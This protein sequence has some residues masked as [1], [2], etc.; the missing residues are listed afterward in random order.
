MTGGL[1]TA[2]PDLRAVGTEVDGTVAELGLAV[3]PGD[4]LD[5]ADPPAGFLEP[6][7]LGV[8]SHEDEPLGLEAQRPGVGIEDAVDQD[9][10]ALREQ[11]VHVTGGVL[12]GLTQVVQQL[13]AGAAVE[14]DV[15]EPAVGGGQR[16]AA[17]LRV[18]PGHLSRDGV[19]EREV[20]VP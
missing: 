13:C 15:E 12:V 17:R 20:D 2:E 6:E 7:V 3:E 9:E 16:E 8:A 5:L 19:R 18:E 4:L 10:G 11:L 14:A 1:V